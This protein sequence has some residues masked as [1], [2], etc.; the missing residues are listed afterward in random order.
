MVEL[1]MKQV[2]TLLAV[3]IGTILIMTETNVVKRITETFNNSTV[4]CRNFDRAVLNGVENLGT[5]TATR[6]KGPDYYTLEVI[7][8]LPDPKGGAFADTCECA[9]YKVF[10]MNNSGQIIALDRFYDR[11]LD[12][13]HRF[14]FSSHNS[15]QF[16]GFNHILVSFEDNPNVSQPSS[17][18]LRGKFDSNSL[19][20]ND[21]LVQM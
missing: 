10:L 18:V 6:S 19:F 11:D 5:G 7:A 14:S 4:Q 9:F 1:N 17:I 16:N 20:C 2:G 13:A 21:E 3:L 12:G 15:D 8:N